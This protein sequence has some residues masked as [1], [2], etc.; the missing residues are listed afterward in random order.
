M[1]S[2]R[3]RQKEKSRWVKGSGRREERKI[4]RKRR[5]GSTGDCMEKS[6]TRLDAIGDER[7]L[8]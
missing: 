3:K 7:L 8:D 6:S 1:F 5:R 2:D 4:A